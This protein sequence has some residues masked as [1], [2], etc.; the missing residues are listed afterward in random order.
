MRTQGGLS[1]T[2]SVHESDLA[3]LVQQTKCL[4]ITYFSL[5]FKGFIETTFPNSPGTPVEE[6]HCAQRDAQATMFHLGV[7]LVM[8]Q[9]L[10]CFVL[11]VDLVLAQ[12][13][14]ASAETVLGILSLIFSMLV[15]MR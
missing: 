11:G 6:R 1:H 5:F 13:A 4:E 15:I 7:D 9:K 2:H 3:G 8:V 10:R 14:Q 12:K